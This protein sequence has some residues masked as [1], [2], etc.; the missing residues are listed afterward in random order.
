ME[1]NNELA[2]LEHFVDKLLG[3]YKGLQES[4]RQLEAKFVARDA[5]CRQL[6]EQIEELRN[7]RHQI[8]ERVAGLLDRIEQWE[9]ECDQEENAEHFAKEEAEGVQGELFAGGV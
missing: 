2:R 6:K 7:E 5:E 9:T 4:Y 3:K 1:N 8:G